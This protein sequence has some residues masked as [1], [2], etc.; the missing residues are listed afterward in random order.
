MFHGFLSDV[1]ST[2]KSAPA[3]ST[4]LIYGIPLSLAISIHLPHFFA[5]YGVNAPARTVGSLPNIT[6]STPA[7]TP[8]PA[9]VPPPMV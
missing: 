1:G 5:A 9:T 4:K 3:D 7:I 2:L 8:I 6:H